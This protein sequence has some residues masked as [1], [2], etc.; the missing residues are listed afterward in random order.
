MGEVR[1]L[2]VATPVALG[3]L[4]TPEM[5]RAEF[6]G[7]LPRV[8]SVRWVAAQLPLSKRQRVGKGYGWW[9]ADVRDAL[10]ARA[11]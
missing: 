9:E 8:P 2:Q 1:R 6:Y 7:H 3:R 11:A 4:L 5:V 10:R